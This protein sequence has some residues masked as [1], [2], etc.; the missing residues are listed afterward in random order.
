MN[1]DSC[2][3]RAEVGEEIVC[4]KRDTLEAGDGELK[5]PTSPNLGCDA[6]TIVIQN[7]DGERIVICAP[8]IFVPYPGDYT[9]GV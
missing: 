8:E 4:I 1:C 6:K 3:W 5:F 7:A 9:N 2:L